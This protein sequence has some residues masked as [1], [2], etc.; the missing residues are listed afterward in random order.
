MH[1][2][3]MGVSGVGKTA[4]GKGIATALSLRF[5]DADDFHPMCNVEKMKSREG[6]KK[7]IKNV[8]EN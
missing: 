2:I 5:D 8:I 7:T 6:C 3:V 4:V 1:I